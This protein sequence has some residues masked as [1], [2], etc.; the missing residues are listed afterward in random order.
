M[1]QNVYIHK[2][3]PFKT[4][5]ILLQSGVIH[6][7]CLCCVLVSQCV[8]WKFYVRLKA[9]IHFNSIFIKIYFRNI[10]HSKLN[11]SPFCYCHIAQDIYAQSKTKNTTKNKAEQTNEPNFTPSAQ[12]NLVEIVIEW[13]AVQLILNEPFQTECEIVQRA[14]TE[15]MDASEKIAET[16]RE[17]LRK[18]EMK[19]MN[20]KT[21]SMPFH[22]FM[23]IFMTLKHAKTHLLKIYAHITLL[24][25]FMNRSHFCSNLMMCMRVCSFSLCVLFLSL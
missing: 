15:I 2:N 1:W 14:C 25:H 11:V 19:E 7:L 18:R 24:D 4:T 5:S 17:W 13:M 20:Y 16:I 22:Y 3:W 12:L 9:Y 8:A 6:I 10:K 23:C 21:L